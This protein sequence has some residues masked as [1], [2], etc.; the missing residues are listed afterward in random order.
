[1]R[2]ILK[3]F[4]PSGRIDDIVGATATYHNT[5][6]T[7][8]ATLSFTYSFGKLTNNQ[9]KRDTGSA[10]SEQSRWIIKKTNWSFYR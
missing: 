10:D 6:D 8:V 2:D 4:S 1:M 7:Q 9:R 3:T 5:V